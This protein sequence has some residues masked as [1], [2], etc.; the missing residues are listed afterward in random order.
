MET[1]LFNTPGDS[2]A[3]CAQRAATSPDQG[4]EG[5]VRGNA[6][7]VTRSV[8]ELIRNNLEQCIRSGDFDDYVRSVVSCVQSTCESSTR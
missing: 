2:G 1:E 7:T 5:T 4:V 8:T 6:R 3:Q